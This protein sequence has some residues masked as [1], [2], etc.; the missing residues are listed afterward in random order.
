MNILKRFFLLSGNYNK[1]Y[2]YGVY[3]AYSRFTALAT[4]MADSAAGSVAGQKR[5]VA[6]EQPGGLLATL[7]GD[8]SVTQ[9]WL[10]S[11]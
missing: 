9:R 6:V 8:T 5:G 2:L 7:I 10:V 4:G 3:Q 11:N 1:I